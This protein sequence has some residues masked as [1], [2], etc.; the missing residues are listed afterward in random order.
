MLNQ[1]QSISDGLKITAP[2]FDSLKFSKQATKRSLRENIRESAEK[3]G[4]VISVFSLRH[5]FPLIDADFSAKSADMSAKIRV[6]IGEYLR[7]DLST[8]NQ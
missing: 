3:M 5:F 6:F 4:V 7:E 1:K 8:L 2:I